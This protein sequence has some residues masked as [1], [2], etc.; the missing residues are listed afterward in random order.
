[1]A[2]GVNFVVVMNGVVNTILMVDALKTNIVIL[3]MQQIGTMEVVL[4]NLVNVLMGNQGVIVVVCVMV[5]LLK[6]ALIYA[7]DPF[8]QISVVN[9]GEMG[10]MRDMTVMGIFCQIIKN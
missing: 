5:L 10:Q 3:M 1:M 8:K 7:M 2:T 6:I 4:L 9:V